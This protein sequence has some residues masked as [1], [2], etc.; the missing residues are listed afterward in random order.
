MHKI[1]DRIT[2]THIFGDVT[3][4]D[5]F[6]SPT[7]QNHCYEVETVDGEKYLVSEEDLN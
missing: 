7:S 3:I 6:I 2:G 5:A 1:G 4:T